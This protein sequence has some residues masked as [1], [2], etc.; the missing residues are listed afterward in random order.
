[1]E[2]KR[3]NG[4]QRKRVS[5]PTSEIGP[6]AA[7]LPLGSIGIKG[8]YGTVSSCLMAWDLLAM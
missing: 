6:L 3:R 8:K 2:R 7:V 4:R 1:M 5:V